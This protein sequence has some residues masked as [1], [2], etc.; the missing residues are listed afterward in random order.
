[1]IKSVYFSFFFLFFSVLQAQILDPVLWSEQAEKKEASV[2]EEIKLFFKIKMEPNWYVYANDFDPDCGPNLTTFNFIP[3]DS[4]RLIGDP[5]GEDAKAKYDEI[6]ECDVKIF[7]NKGTFSQKIK[8]LK[9]DLLVEG[10]LEFQTCNEISGVCLPPKEVDFSFSNFVIKEKI[11]VSEEKKEEKENVE[12]K[13]V[14]PSEKNINKTQKDEEK[15]N[16]EAKE[17]FPS[18]KNIN[19]IQINE[20]KEPEKQVADANEFREIQGPILSD[21][22]ANEGVDKKSL[23]LFAIF[24]FLAGLTALLTPCVFPMIPMTVTFFTGKNYTKFHSLMYGGFIILIY[25]IVGAALS[26]LMGPETAN[27]LSTEWFPNLLF[28]LIFLIFAL[29]FFG[30]FE[31]N[32]PTSFVNKIDKKADK[33]GLPG[34]FFMAFTLVLVSFSCT[35]P[36]VGSI[37]VASAGGEFLRPIIGMLSFSLA[38]AIPFTLF[39]IFPGMMKKLP[40]SGGWLNSVKVVLGFVELALAFKFLSIADQAFH[41]GILDRDVNIAIWVVIFSLMG[42]YLLGKIQ[43]PHDTKKESIGVPRLLLAIATFSFVL[44][45]IPGLW[46]APLKMLAGYLPPMHT[47]DFDLIGKYSKIDEGEICDN[48]PKYSDFLH[49]PHGLKGYFDYAEALECARQ[50]NKPVFIDF[51]GHGC[52]N[53]REMEAVVWSDPEVL[54][55]LQDEYVLLALYVDDKTE[56]PEKEWFVSDYDGKIKKTIGKQN[57]D[58]QITRLKNNA[59]PFY[60]LL[61][62]DEQVLVAPVGYNRDVKDFIMFLDE[63]V[64]T[65]QSK[66]N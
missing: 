56:L 6:F 65:F 61:G 21:S 26:P 42:L 8:I 58:L 20:E 24:A 57:A 18:D 12:A 1:M 32:I 19:K 11:D 63:G 15:E 40:K 31:I 3:N 30:M 23:W 33:G 27:H 9:K 38:F 2:G 53:C 41:W 43:L 50:Q 7:V 54:Q 34:V 55:R 47:H 10:S 60:V 4:Y 36:I 5:V 29:S 64:K 46:G 35:G 22:L 66:Y 44:Y 37:I 51:T 28:F 17:I 52:T 59:Q 48:D 25:T 14:F 39:A 45:L 13:E 49:F 16:V 62:I